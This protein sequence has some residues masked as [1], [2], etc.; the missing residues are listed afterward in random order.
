MFGSAVFR[1]RQAADRGPESP[2]EQ[3]LVLKLAKRIDEPERTRIAKTIFSRKVVSSRCFAAV[4]E[5]SSS[6]NVRSGSSRIRRTK[7]GA[8]RAPYLLMQTRRGL[9]ARA[10]EESALCSR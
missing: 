2:H 4:L 6:R 8:A 9:V 7:G 1:R 3:N 5:S 10:D